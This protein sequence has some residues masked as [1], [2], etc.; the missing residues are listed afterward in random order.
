MMTHSVPNTI[1]EQ[2][3]GSK[4]LSM[5]GARN[6]VGSSDSLQMHLPTRR[7]PMVTVR[8]DPDDTYSVVVYRLQNLQPKVV[9]AVH[10]VHVAQLRETF[11]RLTG[12]E[13]SL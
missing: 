1:L 6:F 13:T 9:T 5:T 11:T 3:G 2:L 8:L 7:S 4:F 10:D 12:L